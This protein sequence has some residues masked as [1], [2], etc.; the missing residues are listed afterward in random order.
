[1]ASF[2]GESF[3]GLDLSQ[4][5][6]SLLKYRR[7]ISKRVLLIEFGVSSVILAEIKVRNDSIALDHIRRYLLPEDALERGIPADPAQMAALIKE[8]CKV[9][10]IPAHRAAVVVPPDAAFSTLIQLPQ[11]VASEE[12]LAYVLDPAS[13]LQVPVQL[14][15]MEVELTPL[16]M[17]CSQLD[18]RCYFLTAVPKKLVDRVKPFISLALSCSSFR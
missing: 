14:D 15:Q 1:M 11:S 4:I 5:K 6:S 7:R 9:E 16:S 12:A 13:S 17:P 8:H 3:F 10:D 2:V 18:H